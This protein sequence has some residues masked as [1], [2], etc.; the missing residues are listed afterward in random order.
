MGRWSA[1]GSGWSAVRSERP[2]R[3]AKQACSRLVGPTGRSKP[4]FPLQGVRLR[5]RAPPGPWRDRTLRVRQLCADVQWWRPEFPEARRR[6]RSS[7][8]RLEPERS[9]PSPKPR[10]HAERRPRC[11]TPRGGA[12][13]RPESGRRK[14]ACRWG[15][16]ARLLTYTERSGQRPAGNAQF[17]ACLTRCARLRY[18]ALLGWR[19]LSALPPFVVCKPSR[20]VSLPT[21]NQLV[22]KGRTAPK[23]KVKTPALRGAPQKRGVCTRVYTDHAEEA[24][25]GASQGRARPP[26][27]R[28]GSR[29]L[30]PRRGPQPPGALGRADPRRPRQGPAG[31]PLQGDPCCAGLVGVADRKQGRSKY[32][33]KRGS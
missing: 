11:R 7:A 2:Q 17:A 3:S 23:A 16:R 9:C 33:A 29:R 4:P 25:L 1:L 24:E 26:H 5:W 20:G 22:R 19:G 32:G 30:H 10:R 12:A 27:E 15:T 8:G 18:H 14:T 13:R 31:L 21:V 6:I 28:H